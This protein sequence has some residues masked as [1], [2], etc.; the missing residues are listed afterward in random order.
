[1]HKMGTFQPTAPSD[2]SMP[3]MFLPKQFIAPL[4]VA[5]ALVQVP[6]LALAAGPG[7]N[8]SYTAS[9]TSGTIKFKVVKR[10]VQFNGYQGNMIINGKTYPGIFYAPNNGTNGVGFVWYYPNNY[11]QA[12]DALVYPQSDGSYSGSIEF[13]NRKGAVSDSGVMTV[14][15]TF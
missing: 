10:V 11:A 1:M 9:Q 5:F 3:A 4:L 13:L 2:Q 12:G 7:V 15:I 8:G 6:S 14:T